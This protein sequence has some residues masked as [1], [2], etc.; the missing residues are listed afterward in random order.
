[1]GLEEISSD[2]GSTLILIALP[3]VSLFPKAPEDQ[4]DCIKGSYCS[5]CSEEVWLSRKKRLLILAHDRGHQKILKF[6]YECGKKHKQDIFGENKRNL[7]VL[8]I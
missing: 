1:M 8:N 3:N 6:C 5:F 2:S 7:E 4:L